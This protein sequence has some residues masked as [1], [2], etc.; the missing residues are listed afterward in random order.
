M[1]WQMGLIGGERGEVVA[2]DNVVAGG[3]KWVV[4][5]VVARECKLVSARVGE[6]RWV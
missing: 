4:G 2:S 1:Q 5:V 6:G 3:R